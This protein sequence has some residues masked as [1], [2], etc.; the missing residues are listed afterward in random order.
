MS[1][2]LIKMP[3]LMAFYFIIKSQLWSLQTQKPPH[4][5]LPIVTN[6]KKPSPLVAYT[7]KIKPPLTL[8]RPLLT[9]PFVIWANFFRHFGL[10]L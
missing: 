9:A 8:E 10:R 6:S 7:C 5:S 1:R 3:G 2:Y 4:P